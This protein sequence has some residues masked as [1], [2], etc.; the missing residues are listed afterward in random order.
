[1]IAQRGVNPSVKSQSKGG[2]LRCKLVLVWADHSD[3]DATPWNA[4]SND[5]EN[6]QRKTTHLAQ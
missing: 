1:M 4:A 5:D 3:V 2:G 6:Q